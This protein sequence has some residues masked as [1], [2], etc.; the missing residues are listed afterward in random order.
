MNIDLRDYFAAM[1]TEKDM[2]EMRDYIA[3]QEEAEYKMSGNIKRYEKNSL[4]QHWRHT[5]RYLHADMMLQART[6]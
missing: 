5:A 4:P 2:E 1:A 3:F 6:K